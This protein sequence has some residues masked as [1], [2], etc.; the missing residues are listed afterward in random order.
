MALQ[1]DLSKASNEE[2]RTIATSARYGKKT[3]AAAREKL[4]ARGVEAPPD[5]VI[6]EPA[7]PRPRSKAPIG[8]IVAG[9]AV[10]VVAMS[11]WKCE[12][13]DSII[14]IS[15]MAHRSVRPEPVMPSV[16]SPA[17]GLSPENQSLYGACF[18]SDDFGACTK[19]AARVTG[20]LENTSVDLPLGVQ[21]YEHACTG[22]VGIAC[23]ELAV[24][25]GKGRGVERD[26]A[27]SRSYSG[28]ACQ[29][30]VQQACQFP[31]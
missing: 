19:L 8:A 3:R 14:V 20:G 21:L 1:D 16:P 29:L 22:G 9:V 7:P 12:H 6:A 28:L 18:G 15:P 26:D 17:G 5:E 24:A 2:L 27:M 31:Q 23:A 13:D 30:G 11:V 4:A 10:A 25:Y